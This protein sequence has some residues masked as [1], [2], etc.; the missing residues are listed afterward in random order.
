M[1]ILFGYGID[2]KAI[3]IVLGFLVLYSLINMTSRGVNFNFTYT[4]SCCNRNYLS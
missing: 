2:R 1:L 4:S 3:Y